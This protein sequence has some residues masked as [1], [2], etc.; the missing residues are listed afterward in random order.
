MARVLLARRDFQ[1]AEARV[2]RALSLNARSPEA[3]VLK[4]QLLN[5][6]GDRRNALSALDTA[7]Q[8]SPGMLAARL[9]RANLLVALG[10]DA[11]AKEDV[12]TVLRMEPRSAGGIYLQAVLAA[13][14]REFQ[15][16]DA[17]LTQ[18]ANLLPRFPRGYFFLG[19][20]KFNLGQG[21]QALDA[22]QRFVQRNP[23][24]LDG[25]KL[26]ARIHIAGQR[27]A[28][29]VQLLRKAIADGVTADAEVFDILG[30]AHAQEGR[31]CRHRHPPGRHAPGHG[32]C[33]RGGARP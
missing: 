22:A 1:G 14:A 26:L 31:Q 10:D 12:T 2:D 19:V 7:I 27:P 33:H 24:D 3:L 13:R 4:A 17:A 23:T 32:R 18:I 28:E 21:E 20:V 29:A 9:E 6:R 8:Q 30:R 11:K 15:A 25:L 5:L 16:A